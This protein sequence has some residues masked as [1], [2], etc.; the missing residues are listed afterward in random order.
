MLRGSTFYC[1][2]IV[3]SRTSVFIDLV[4]S[5]GLLRMYTIMFSLCKLSILG[6]CDIFIDLLINLYYDER[7]VFKYGNLQKASVVKDGVLAVS[8]NQN[9]KALRRQICFNA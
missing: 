6:S 3:C 2:C 7:E 5:F 9:S 4:L 1:L 8:V